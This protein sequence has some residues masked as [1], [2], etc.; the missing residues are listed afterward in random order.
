MVTGKP[1]P[2]SPPPPSPPPTTQSNPAWSSVLQLA[3]QGLE[4]LY[5]RGKV[6]QAEY[7]SKSSLLKDLEEEMQNARG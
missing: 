6:D 5:L 7:A 2:P 1:P 3:S 4:A